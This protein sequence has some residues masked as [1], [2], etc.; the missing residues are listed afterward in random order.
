MG[1]FLFLILLQTNLIPLFFPVLVFALHAWLVPQIVR[2]ASRGTR[3]AL[4]WR[5]V[6]GT[7]AARTWYGA[8]FA[9]GWWRDNVLFLERSGPSPRPSLYPFLHKLS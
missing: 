7:A 8:Y 9:S 2:N 5:Y 3:R 6:L 4:S 1:M